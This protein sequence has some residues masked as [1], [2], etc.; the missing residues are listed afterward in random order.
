[1][2]YYIGNYK[3]QEYWIEQF[4]SLWVLRLHIYNDSKYIDS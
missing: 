2:G 1:M 3:I 4:K